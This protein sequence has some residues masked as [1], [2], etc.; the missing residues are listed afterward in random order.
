MHAL[1]QDA[2]VPMLE[3]IRAAKAVAG[4]GRVSRVLLIGA[5]TTK[6]AVEA[7]KETERASSLGLA[8]VDLAFEEHEVLLSEG[9]LGATAQAVT[10][11]PVSFP[12]WM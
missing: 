2:A 6:L 4:S 10:T 3:A 5:N 11:G 1:V 9:S 12:G 7:L 8:D